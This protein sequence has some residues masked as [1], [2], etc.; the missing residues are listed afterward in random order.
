MRIPIIS[1]LHVDEFTGPIITKY[2]SGMTN[3]MVVKEDGGR[4]YVT[5]RPP[6]RLIESASIHH[7]DARGRAVYF[8]EF[9]DSSY[10]VNNDKVYKG[11]QSN[12][13]G[14]ISSGTTK[15]KFL[16]LDDKLCL[17]DFENNEAWV[18]TTADVF[19]QI[20]DVDF[21]TTLAYGAEVLNGHLFLLDEDGYLFNSAFEDLTSWGALDFINAERDPDGGSFLGKHHDDL[22]VFGPKTEEFF[23]YSNNPTES[24]LDRRPGVAYNIGCTSG[25]TVWQV[26]DLAFY[27]GVNPSGGLAAYKLSN[28]QPVKISKDDLDTLLTAAMIDEEYRAIGQG[29]YAHGRPFYVLTFYKISGDIVPE[30]SLVYDDLTGFWG[31]W[32]T[33]IAGHT[34]FPIVDWSIREG[35]LPRYGEGILSNGDIVTM[36]NSMAA[37]DTTDALGYMDADYVDD[38]YVEEIGAGSETIAMTLRPGMF[39]GGTNKTKFAGKLDLV[40]DKTNN[41][42]AALIKWSDERSDDFNDGYEIDTSRHDPITRCG[43]F[44]RRNH[45]IEYSENER[46]KWEFMEM[47]ASLGRS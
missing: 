39:D 44:R 30:M 8:W 41:S 46:V 7:A 14:T 12:A 40:G 21:P 1:N 25:E 37:S 16:P 36:S 9:N 43:T 15:C 34:L 42:N 23:F 2:S 18:I 32:S 19:T 31:P 13:I 35:V 4:T 26:G 27:V 11:S 29:I 45:Q 6:I 28:F 33:V 20:T 3:A 17:V 10:S 5:Q 24:P 47:N 22:Y 38:D